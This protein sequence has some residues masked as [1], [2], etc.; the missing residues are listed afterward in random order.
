[1]LKQ[2][3]QGEYNPFNIIAL[4]TA[5]EIGTTTM[6]TYFYRV[7]SDI[8]TNERSLKDIGI[9]KVYVDVFCE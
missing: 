5:N 1:M 9:I 2:N 4:A 3:P 8:A 7:C 6:G